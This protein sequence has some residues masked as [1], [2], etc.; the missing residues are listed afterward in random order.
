MAHPFTAPAH[1]SV[2]RTVNRKKF[3]YNVIRI[4]SSTKIPKI[5]A[6]KIKPLDDSYALFTVAMEEQLAND[7]AF[8]AVAKSGPKAVR[9]VTVQAAQSV[10]RLSITLAS[11]ES[12][13]TDVQQAFGIMCTVLARCANCCEFLQNHVVNI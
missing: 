3:E 9:S 12:V 8:V 7:V 13:P 11:N 10:A 5:S 6:D 4:A 2:W 1:L